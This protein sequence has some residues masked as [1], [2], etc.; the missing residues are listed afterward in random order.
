[1]APEQVTGSDVGPAAD[2][3]SLAT[4]AYEMFAGVIPFDGQGLMELLYAHVHRDPVPP[5][6]HNRSL[7]THV[8]E[9]ILR[10]LARDP[11]SRWESC[12]AFVDA[13]A[14]ALDEKSEPVAVRTMVMTAA[15][16]STV[17]LAPPVAATAVLEPRLADAVS[18]NATVAIPYPAPAQPVAES[19]S[20]RR[21]IAVVLAAALVVLLV[22]GAIWYAARPLTPTLSLSASTVTAGDTVVVT[23]THVPANQDGTIQL[24]SARYDFSFRSDAS[25]N[26]I[27]DIT[28]PQDIEAGDHVVKICWASTCPA[29]TTLHVATPADAATPS[30]DATTPA[31]P[32]VSPQPTAS[33]G[34]PPR[35]GTTPTPAP[36]ATPSAS[37]APSPTP[38]PA[39]YVTVGSISQLYGFTA[40]LRYFGGGTWTIS[41][42]DVTLARSFTAGTATVPTGSTYFSQHFG[43]PLGVVAGNQAYVTACNSSGKCYHSNTITVGP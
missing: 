19:Q 11:A 32:G 26:V 30:P 31:T 7:N 28:I 43:T 13:L 12:T 14:A 23:A 17:T 15:G 1:M 2:R 42:F 6:A 10:G 4:I 25:G 20:R 9:V 8:D 38:T 21:T 29:S 34:Q 16:A 22:L 35:P 39:P 36:R 27:R 18:P 5:S 33:P 40:V 3:Y 24:L 37:P 41:V